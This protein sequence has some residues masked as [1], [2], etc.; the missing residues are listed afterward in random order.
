MGEMKRARKRILA[1]NN[2]VPEKA[3]V[4]RIILGPQA[5][6]FAVLS[7]MRPALCDKNQ[8]QIFGSMKVSEMIFRE[9]FDGNI[10][11]WVRVW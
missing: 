4:N 9:I 1:S 5:Y 10:A 8:N 11:R 3:L 6:Q 7:W 2:V